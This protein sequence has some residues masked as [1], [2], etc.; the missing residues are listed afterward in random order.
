MNKNRQLACRTS[1]KIQSKVISFCSVRSKLGLW[2]FFTTEKTEITEHNNFA[3]QKAEL[4]L[5]I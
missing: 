1:A 2:I 5:I 4:C 3:F